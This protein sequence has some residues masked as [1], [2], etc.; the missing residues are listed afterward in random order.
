MGGLGDFHRG[1]VFEGASCTFLGWAEWASYCS[2]FWDQPR[3]RCE[4]V[5]VFGA[6]GYRRTAEIKRPKL[7]PFIGQI[8]Q[9][10][11][12]DKARPRKQRHTA[13]RIFEHLLDECG[14]D[15]G[16]TIVKDYVR[17]KKRG[18][19]EMFVPLSHPPGHGVIPPDINGVRK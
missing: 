15:G 6:A 16:Y 10:L 4:D 17:T 7:D 11:I 9:W 19:R 14:L 8:E 18:A 2:G 1:V 13:R 12:E 5:S 3:Q